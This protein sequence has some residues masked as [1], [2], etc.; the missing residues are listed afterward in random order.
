MMSPSSRA[1]T[2]SPSPV[3]PIQSKQQRK[4]IRKIWQHTRQHR[5]DELP[6]LSLLSSVLLVL[7]LVVVLLLVL[8]VVFSLLVVTQILTHYN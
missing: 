6:V 4:T 3:R 2:A 5:L 1:V 8:V 7:L